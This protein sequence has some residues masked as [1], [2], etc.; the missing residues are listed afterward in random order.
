MFSCNF[1]IV[2]QVLSVSFRFSTPRSMYATS[3]SV[4]IFEIDAIFKYFGRRNIPK[5]LCTYSIYCVRFESSRLND[6]NLA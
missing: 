2:V 1:V 3:F 6:Y 4:A 5:I